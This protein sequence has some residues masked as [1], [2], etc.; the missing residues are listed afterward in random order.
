MK[1]LNLFGVYLAPFAGYVFVTTVLFFGVRFWLDRLEIEKWF[2]HRSLL[3]T[4]IF[5]IILSVIGLIF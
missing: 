2:W 1:E 5:I 4:A 3:D